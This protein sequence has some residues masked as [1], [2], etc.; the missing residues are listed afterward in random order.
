VNLLTSVAARRSPR[1]APSVTSRSIRASLST[2]SS[3]TFSGY[4]GFN[5]ANFAAWT[6]F[7][8]SYAGSVAPANVVNV[9]ATATGTQQFYRLARVDYSACALADRAGNSFTFSNPLGERC[10]LREERP[11]V[12]RSSTDRNSA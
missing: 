10:C 6:R 7:H 11:G 5:S 2:A 12:R 3:R 4:T 8:L 9:S 1:R